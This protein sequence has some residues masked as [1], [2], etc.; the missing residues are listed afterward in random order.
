[1]EESYEPGQGLQ[2][3]FPSVLSEALVTKSNAHPSQ[4]TC[5]S[6][7][8]DTRTGILQTQSCGFRLRTAGLPI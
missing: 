4:Q 5:A 8:L 7:T 1:M 2:L 3:R 6:D